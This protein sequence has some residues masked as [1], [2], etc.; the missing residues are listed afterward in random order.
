IYEVRD[1]PGDQGGYVYLSWDA[2]REDYFMGDLLTHYTLWRA[3]DPAPALSMVETGAALLVASPGD[4]PDTPGPVIRRQ[5]LGSEIYFWELVDSQDAYHRERYG[6][7]VGTL[8]DSTAVS[9]E[10][11]YFQVVAHTSDPTVYWESEP[12]SGYSVDNLAPCP[13]AMLAGEQSFVPE[14][15]TLTWAP[16]IEIDLDGYAIYRGVG[17][18]FTPGPGNLLTEPC[19]TFYFDGDWRWDID[20]CYKVAAVDIHGNE[21]EYTLLCSDDVTGDETSVPSAS[22]LAQN[23][24]NPF[25]PT[26]TIRFGLPRAVHVKLSVYNVKGELISTIFNQHMTEGRKEI[27]WTAKDSRGQTVSS[28][29]YFY[30]LVAG[31]FVQTK[32]MVLLR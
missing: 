7:S 9:T 13:P 19:D 2:S 30:R 18:G 16:N 24:P 31:D 1:V 25:N 29:I 4:T 10:Y 15:L 21:S 11:H 5:I 32:K 8:F 27:T 22:F 14:G 12:D 23:V 28:G 3:I 6:K 17:P 20:Y 26:T